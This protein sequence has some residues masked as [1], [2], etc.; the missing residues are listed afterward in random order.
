MANSELEFFV[1]GHG[2]KPQVIHAALGDRLRDVLVRAGLLQEG[3]DDMLVFVGESEEA[4]QEPN[5][6]EDGADEQAPVD[7]NLTLEKLALHRHRHVHCHRCRRIAVDVNFSGQTKERKFSPATTVAVVTRWARKKLKLDDAA[8]AEY[9][10]RLC[11]TN[12]QPRAD[13]HLGE[14]VGATCSLCFDFVKEVTP[15]G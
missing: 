4:L 11:G 14:L 1:H 5:D 7:V 15:Q 13:K 8:A 6:V 3:Q 2:A 12:D 10:L 9:V